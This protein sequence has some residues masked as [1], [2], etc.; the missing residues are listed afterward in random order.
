MDMPSYGRPF[1]RTL[2]V[3]PR[4]VKARSFAVDRSFAFG[5]LIDIAAR[6]QSLGTTGAGT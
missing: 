2:L 6:L 1:D 4:A 5:Q 3:R